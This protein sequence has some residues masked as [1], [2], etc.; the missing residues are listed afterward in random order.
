MTP[1]ITLTI[2][3]KGNEELISHIVKTLRDS[4]KNVEVKSAEKK[5][6]ATPGIGAGTPEF[7]EP[8]A[9]IQEPVA[10]PELITPEDLNALAGQVAKAKGR[11]PVMELI[12]GYA[13]S[14]TL[15]GIPVTSY[16]QFK[17]DLELLLVAA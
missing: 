3:V 6:Q 16:E 15:K 12:G 10:Q 8:A 5:K 4:T 13:K 7:V 11:D 14:G 2:P 1:S 17:E 9:P